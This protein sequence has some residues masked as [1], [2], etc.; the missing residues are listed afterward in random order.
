MKDTIVNDAELVLLLETGDERAFREIYDRYWHKLY[1]MAVGKVGSQENAKEL[2]QDIF[3]DLWFRRNEVHIDELDRYL[4]SAVK[5]RVLNFIKKEIVKKKYEL[6]VFAK[7]PETNRSTEDTLAFRELQQAIMTGIEQLPPKV[8]HIFRLNRIEHRSA[9][10]ISEL[11]K[12]P[13][14]TVEYNITQALR[15]M[16]EYLKDYVVYLLFFYFSFPELI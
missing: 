10:E 14:R 6:S 4:S 5:Y 1:R 15:L 9:F 12:M 11:L 8:Q 13:E 7:S 16:R 3:L 2:I